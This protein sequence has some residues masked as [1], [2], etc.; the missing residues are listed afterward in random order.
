MVTPVR[1]EIPQSVVDADSRGP[2]SIPP[3]TD[4]TSEDY[5]IVVRPQPRRIGPHLDRDPRLP[6][7]RFE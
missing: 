1:E 2:A 4:W 5:G 6:N 7:E 3:K